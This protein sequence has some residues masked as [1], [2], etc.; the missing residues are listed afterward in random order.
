MVGG[1]RNVVARVDKRSVEV[2]HIEV[3][4]RHSPLR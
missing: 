3:K 1:V 2:E 4:H